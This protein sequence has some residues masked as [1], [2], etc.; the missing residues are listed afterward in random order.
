M[1]VL[2]HGRHVCASLKG[3]NRAYL[4]KALFG[5]PTSSNNARLKHSR[6][7]VLGEVVYIA[8]IYHILDS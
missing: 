4:A 8:I 3:T 1:F 6:D 5:C 7:L 2:L